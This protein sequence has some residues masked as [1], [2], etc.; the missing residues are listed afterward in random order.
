MKKLISSLLVIVL[1]VSAMF[2]LT[3][4]NK[5][6]EE[7]G[8]TAGTPSKVQAKYYENAETCDLNDKWNGLNVKFA[9][10]KDKGF[11]LSFT[12]KKAEYQKVILTSKD[13]NCKMT[14]NFLKVAANEIEKRKE[15]YD[16]D[17]EKYSEYSEIE[18]AG[19]KGNSVNYTDWS[20]V[21]K[22]GLLMLQEFED[23][24]GKNDKFWYGLSFAIEK[25]STSSSAAEFDAAEYYNLEEFQNLLNSII[26]TK[27]EPVKVD[28][29]LGANRDLVVKKL[30]AP[31]ADYTVA[32][33]KDT[34]GVMSAYMLTDGK[35]NGSGAYFRVYNATNLDTTKFATL[36]KV[37]E[38]YSGGSWNYTFTD[39]TLGDQAVKVEHN[40]KANPTSDKY[41]IWESGYFEKDGKVYNFLYYRYE[42]VPEEIGT[43]LIKDVLA[44]MYE[45]TEE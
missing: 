44:N 40:P 16:K 31:S 7:G 38:Y 25:S 20:G 1:L 24:E 10:P 26:F 22:Y 35:Y 23:E 9:Y 5:G 34:N 45:Y 17:T 15:G 4:C 8:E 18:Y 2:V 12:D 42:D 13:M 27:T 3:A 43:Q 37:L 6:G 14:F 19:Y 33:Y 41:S 39:E 11:E 36:D 29:T 32:Q 28:G 30:T 21:K